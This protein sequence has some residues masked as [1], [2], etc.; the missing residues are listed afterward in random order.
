MLQILWSSTSAK[1]DSPAKTSPPTQNEIFARTYFTDLTINLTTTTLQRLLE[2]AGH[3]VIRQEVQSLSIVP[4][5]ITA[6][7]LAHFAKREIFTSVVQQSA[8][9]DKSEREE[10]LTVK[11]KS[12]AIK[13]IA[14][15]FKS[16]VE[17]DKLTSKRTDILTQSLRAFP[18]CHSIKMVVQTDCVLG[19]K[20]RLPPYTIG[21]WGQPKNDITATEIIFDAIKQSNI[22]LQSLGAR[23]IF[24]IG[25]AH[26]TLRH[27]FNSENISFLKNIQ[28][29]CMP[30]EYMAPPKD[31]I[32][33]LKAM[34]HLRD[35]EVEIGYDPHARHLEKFLTKAHLPALRKLGLVTGHI[36]DGTH[37]GESTHLSLCRFLQSHNIEHLVFCDIRAVAIET[38]KLMFVSIG[39]VK[40]LTIL[41]VRLLELNKGKRGLV[42]EGP[43]VMNGDVTGHVKKMVETMTPIEWS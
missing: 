17:A 20:M 36:N 14:A 19:K 38:W 22:Q 18:N 3:P 4:Q 35:L 16:A 31:L 5:C 34:P 30:L 25:W 11:E 43:E 29:L 9:K 28:V 41:E 37:I 27:P 42:W 15:K 21:Q 32:P 23:N 12:K 13:A 33:I 24:E 39:A 10:P 8:K 6:E 1:H 26:Q 40:T 2:L 7:D